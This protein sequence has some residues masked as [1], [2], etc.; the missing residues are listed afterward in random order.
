M[1]DII[2]YLEEAPAPLAEIVLELR[3][4]VLAAAPHAS[5]SIHWRALSY[6]DAERG[7][8][9]KGAICQIT[10][11]TDHVRLSFIHGARLPDPEGLLN[12]DRKSKRYIQFRAWWKADAPALARLVRA[13]A[14]CVTMG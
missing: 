9:V 10:V 6:H 7:G 1:S 4:L 12:G 13:A 14:E 8:M 3:K 5:E 2:Q 11:H